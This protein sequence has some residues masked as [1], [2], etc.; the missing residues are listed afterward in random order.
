VAFG[1]VTQKV[2]DGFGGFGCVK[3]KRDDAVVSDV[4]FDLGITHNV[5]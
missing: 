5:S 2:G 3:L 4:E 1:D